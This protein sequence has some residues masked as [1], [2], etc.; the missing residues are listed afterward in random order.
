MRWHIALLYFFIRLFGHL[1]LRVLQRL[2]AGLG[3][4]FWLRNGKERRIAARNLQL[5]FPEL[6]E[7][8]HA[9]LLRRTLV[10]T[11]KSFLEVMKIWSGHPQAALGLIRE[12]H[13]VE[14]YDA[15]LAD[16]HGLIIAAPH[17]GCW[18]L[19]NF[20][21]CSRAPMAIAYRPP[22]QAD[23]EPLL[24]MA[25]GALQ[26]EQVPAEGAGVR[27]LYKRLSAGG[28]VGIL[29]DQEPKQGE[30]EFAAFFGVHALTMVLISRLARRTGATV[31]FSFAERLPDGAG[32]RLH[33]L[34]APT[35]IADENLNR[36]ASA[37]NQGVEA[38]I[39]IAP[40]QYQWHYKRWSARP[41][42]APQRLY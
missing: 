35:A 24:L 5:A 38:C 21:L 26:A 31:L 22:R 30:G 4:L 36:A 18:E 17:L 40:E 29:P 16:K 41:S 7:S 39:R 13:G 37:L 12:V 1:P 33:F 42:D 8:Q 25:R 6:T 3:W 28:V 34:P 15:A 2:G 10:E 14:F 9:A 11:G 32:Y 20:Y 23:L 27:T 19:L